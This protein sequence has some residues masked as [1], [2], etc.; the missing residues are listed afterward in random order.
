M[1]SS[2]A[3][4]RKTRGISAAGLAALAGVTR[5]AIYAIEA[6]TY[7]PNTTVA[8]RLARA[9][10]TTVENLF[11]LDEE[12][13]VADFRDFLPL[14]DLS[15]A[16]P[17]EP[18]QICRV[19]R[20]NIGVTPTVFPAYLP[21]ADGI[22]CE[23]G[24]ASLVT[25]P[26]DENR[27]LLAGCDPALSLLAA[28]ALQAH[29][30]VVLASGNSSRSLNWLREGRIDIAGTHLDDPVASGLSII[31]FAVWEEGFVVKR[32]NP[33]EIRRIEDLANKAVRFVNRDKGSGS[34]RLFESLLDKAGM[35]PANVA[36][37]EIS[38]PGH[39]AAAWAV[40]SGSADCCVAAG[41]AARRFGLDFIP[42]ASE[43]FDLVLHR[44]DLKRKAVQGL[45]EVLNRSRFRRQLEMFAG[46][47]VSRAGEMVFQ[48]TVQD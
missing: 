28:H 29:V 36:G 8:L 46:Y 34:R 17:G 15:P 23:P 9:L 2:L 3:A 21:V 4:I 12:Q 37:S 42:L 48:T 16:S 20:R 6:G 31:T 24:K 30:E 35:K 41:S 19:G 38:V 45:F 25:E 7:V 33:L 44:R 26:D 47:D 10:E 22:V 11:A 27:L 32:G 43:R 40:A 1:L 14:D 39:L 18:I 13:P 5:Q